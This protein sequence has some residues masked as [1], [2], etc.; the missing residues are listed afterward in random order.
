M[1]RGDG[2]VESSQG[3]VARLRCLGESCCQQTLKRFPTRQNDRARLFVAFRVTSEWICTHG[4]TAAGTF[5]PPCRDT[6]ESSGN[7]SER[8]RRSLTVVWDPYGVFTAQWQ[9]VAREL[10]RVKPEHLSAPWCLAAEWLI[11]PSPSML[12]TSSGRLNV[13]QWLFLHFS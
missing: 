6:P 9:R 2:P 13:P 5:T 11:S 8:D 7:Q 10:L 3:G 12:E 1:G 4:G